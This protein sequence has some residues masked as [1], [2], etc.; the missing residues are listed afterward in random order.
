LG[1]G[2]LLFYPPYIE[3]SNKGSG[4]KCSKD[5]LPVGRPRLQEQAGAKRPLDAETSM[6]YDE[7]GMDQYLLI[8]FLMG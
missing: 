7:M 5:V 2:L 1:D 4:M 3:T 6:K 8:P